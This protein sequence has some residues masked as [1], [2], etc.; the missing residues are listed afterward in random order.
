MIT[1]HQNHPEIIIVAHK[2][3]LCKQTSVFTLDDSIIIKHGTQSSLTIAPLS[4]RLPCAV[5]PHS[6]STPPS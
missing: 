4:P 6:H 3:N 5:T 2:T 1:I